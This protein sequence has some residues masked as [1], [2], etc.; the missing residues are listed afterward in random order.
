MPI[1]VITIDFWNTIFDSSRGTQRNDYRL[2]V[3]GEQISGLGLT[4]PNTS[5]EEAMT[6]SWEYFSINWKNDFHTPSAEETVAFIWDYLKIPYNDE[7]MNNVASS[8]A[9]CVLHFPPALIGNVKDIIGKLSLKYQLGLV[10]D[11]GFSPGSVLR[12]LLHNFNLYDYFDAFSFSNETGY[13]KPHQKAF[14]AILEQLNCKPEQA[15]HIGD[16][17]ETDIAG[18]KSLRMKAVRFSGDAEAYQ[19][20]KYIEPTK[21]DAEILDWNGIFDVIDELEK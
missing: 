5:F 10:S 21:A 4:L 3:L 6:A 16:I 11:T 14:T 7:A 12:K 15:L 9:E 18:A 2:N 8:F 13:A 20:K 19:D 1:K 17:E